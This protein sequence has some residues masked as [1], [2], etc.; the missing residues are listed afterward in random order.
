M[1]VTESLM[2]A[3]SQGGSDTNASGVPKWRRDS[4]AGTFLSRL[5]WPGRSVM[6]PVLPSGTFPRKRGREPVDGQLQCNRQIACSRAFA[7]HP[8]N[9]AHPG[10]PSP[11]SG[12][13]WRAAPD[14][15]NTVKTSVTA[16]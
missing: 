11:A 5:S 13:R 10:F 3:V 7:V 1:E 14:E 4:G 12:R 9:Q 16:R 2:G 15:G 8:E 6:A